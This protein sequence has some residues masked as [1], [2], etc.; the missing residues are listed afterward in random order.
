MLS[1][2]LSGSHQY[3]DPPRAGRCSRHLARRLFK[4]MENMPEAA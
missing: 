4:L 1:G 3:L 2:E